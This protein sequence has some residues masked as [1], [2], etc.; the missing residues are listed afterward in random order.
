MKRVLIV[1]FTE[2]LGGV[3]RL[4]Y[5]YYKEIDRSKLQFDFLINVEKVPFRS[6][7]EKLG[8]RFFVIPRKTKDY[9]GYK[10]RLKAFFDNHAKEYIA[11][12]FNSNSLANLDY[13]TY[14]YRYGIKKRIVHSHNT[15][16][17]RGMVYKVFHQLNKGKARRMATDY[18]ACSVDAGRF[19]F[20]E[21]I[22]KSNK[23][24]VIN[25]AINLHD[26]SFNKEKRTEWRKKIGIDDSVTLYG[27][28]GRLS[29][30]KNHEFLLRAFKML[31]SRHENVHLILIGTGELEE[32]IRRQIEDLGLEKYVSLMGRQFDIPGILQAVDVFVMPSRYEGLPIAAIEAQAAGLPCVLAD[33]ITKEVKFLNSCEYESIASEDKWIL[34]MEKAARELRSSDCSAIKE[35]GFDIEEEAAKLEEYLLTL[36]GLK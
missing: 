12:W 16:E 13:L 29:Y 24:R 10:N 33:T 22:V 9:V 3:E 7:I 31:V 11:F 35:A 21:D 14:A 6:E 1:G 18:W 32:N 8:G 19:F 25:N 34:A 30:Q 2:N 28:V 5:S 20:D 17:T 36:E 23:F 4:I 26:L 15:M 27:N